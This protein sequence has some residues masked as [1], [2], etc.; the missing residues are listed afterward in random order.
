MKWTLFRWICSDSSS[1][2]SRFLHIPCSKSAAFQFLF[3]FHTRLGFVN[4]TTANFRFFQGPFQLTLAFPQHHSVGLFLSFL[5]L[6]SVDVD[7][8][9]INFQG[10]VFEKSRDKVATFISVTDDFADSI[11]LKVF[12]QKL[13]LTLNT[14]AKYYP[15]ST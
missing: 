2:D 8:H 10:T 13:L 5:F 9:A 12:N 3:L 7:K 6:K 4:R 15:V 1:L 14:V 11:L